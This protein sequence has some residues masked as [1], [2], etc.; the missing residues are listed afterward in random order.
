MCSPLHKSAIALKFLVSMDASQTAAQKPLP[1][2][3]LWPDVWLLTLAGV[4]AAF[5]IGKVPPAL[6]LLRAE[7]DFGLTAA[8]WVLSTINLIGMSMGMVAGLL[9]D[10]LGARRAMLGGLAMLAI[11]D[12]AGSFAPSVAMIL[13]SRFAEGIGLFAVAVSAPPLILRATML[14]D[15]RLAMGLWGCY[16]PAGTAAMMLMAPSILHAVGWRGLWIANGALALLCLLTLLWRGERSLSVVRPPTRP[17][18]HSVRETF[19]GPGPL[20][21]AA[22][23]GTYAFAYLALIGFLPTYLVEQRGVDA[24]TAGLLTAAVVA[25]NVIGNLAAGPLQ[26]RGAPRWLLVAAAAASMALCTLLIFDE[27]AANL[28]RYIA[29]LIFSAAGGMA[30]GALFASV[31]HNAPLPSL[32]ATTSGLM[33]Q[34]SNI[35]STLGPPALALLVTMTG[36]WGS[37]AWLLCAMLALC[38]TAAF[39]LGR[40]EK[41][42]SSEH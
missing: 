39:A 24:A 25:A 6:P 22:N 21:L 35:G 42:R 32:I 19:A 26:A 2:R 33:M 1:H 5:H 12:A 18:W 41:R 30:P 20:L 3:T 14:P 23:F 11:A 10:R 29:C 8:G 7:L 31:P 34:G 17:V 27:S 15:Q 36:T 38:M 9:S 37:G 28:W 13:L 4:V 16:M 40:T